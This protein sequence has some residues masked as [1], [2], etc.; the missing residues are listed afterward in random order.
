MKAGTGAIDMIKSFEGLSLMAYFD[1]GTGGEPITIGF[2][3][4]TFED[5]SKIPMG[6]KITRQRAEELLNW[7]V[8]RKAAAVARMV[9][10]VNQNQFDALVSF[11]YN[12]GTGALQRSTLLKKVKANPNDPTI[13]NEFLKW[14]KAGG[15]VMKGLTR[16]R[17]Q[18]A[19]LYFS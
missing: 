15:R 3:S 17:E 10:N 1:P 5:G 14:N 2:G 6:T 11:A 12:V 19:S 4:T 8:Q 7:E 13:K 9:S 18:E 16:R